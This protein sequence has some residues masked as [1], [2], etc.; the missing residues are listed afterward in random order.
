MGHT[1]NSLEN[2]SRLPDKSVYVV[3]EQH[4]YWNDTETHSQVSLYNADFLIII[5]LLTWIK[6]NSLMNAVH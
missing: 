1:V 4:K 5:L 3:C 2:S 6:P